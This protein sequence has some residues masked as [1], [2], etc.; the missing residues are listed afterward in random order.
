[1]RFKLI[2]ITL[3]GVLNMNKKEKLPF[4]TKLIIFSL[5]PISQVVLYFASMKYFSNKQ[6]LSI[7]NSLNMSTTQMNLFQGLLVVLFSLFSFGLMYFLSSSLLN[8]S[9]KKNSK[10]LFISLVLALGAT[11]SVSFLF[12][13]F[14]RLVLPWVATVLQTFLFVV[15][16]YDLSDKDKVGSLLL[17]GLMLIFAVI[18]LVL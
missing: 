6:L 12:V 10:A 11:N 3:L 8:F 17:L 14:F 9:A 4:W 13:E 5:V 2:F 15:S 1:M 16:Y 18:P 7:K